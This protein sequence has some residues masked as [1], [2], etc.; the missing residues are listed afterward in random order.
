MA[1][2]RLME[3]CFWSGART[4]PEL[5]VLDYRAVRF[6]SWRGARPTGD[7]FPP[8]SEHRVRQ[9]LQNAVEQD[10][11]LVYAFAPL[12]SSGSFSSRET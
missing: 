1:T 5:T 9:L 6:C 3:L 10:K 2:A 12:L 11:H 8:S 4:E 7:H